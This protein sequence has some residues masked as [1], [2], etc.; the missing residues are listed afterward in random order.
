MKGNKDM[1]LK[2]TNKKHKRVIAGIL[3]FTLF[4]G[5]ASY[6]KAAFSSGS[7]WKNYSY[8]SSSGEVVAMADCISANGQLGYKYTGSTSLNAYASLKAVVS[9]YYYDSRGILC[10]TDNDDSKFAT[11]VSCEKYVPGG[12]AGVCDNSHKCKTM[13]YVNGNKVRTVYY[14]K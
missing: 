5:S 9:G 1:K 6:A 2:M 13:G 8:G 14:P 10:I 3:M 7:N 4:I 11:Y 12:C